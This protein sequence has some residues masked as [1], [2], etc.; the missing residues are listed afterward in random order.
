V[1]AVTN[2][3]GKFSADGIL[4]LDGE[5]VVWQHLDVQTKQPEFSD[6][7]GFWTFAT[8]ARQTVCLGG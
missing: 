8:L 3:I 6:V 1:K 5:V 7:R 2:S 4:T